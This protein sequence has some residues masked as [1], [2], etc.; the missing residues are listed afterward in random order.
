MKTACGKS[1]TK[2]VDAS[3]ITA[4]MAALA[5]VSSV[6]CK[7]LR[8][9]NKA[10]T[11]HPWCSKCCGLEFPCD[12]RAN[13]E[14]CKYMADQGTAWNSDSGGGWNDARAYGGGSWWPEEWWQSKVE[15]Q[16]KVGRQSAG[17][18][19]AS[20]SDSWWQSK[21]ETQSQR[22]G[23]RKNPSRTQSQGFDQEW[24]MV[25]THSTNSA[26]SSASSSKCPR[27]SEQPQAKWPRE[28][29]REEDVPTEIW[30]SVWEESG[31][32]EKSSTVPKWAASIHEGQA[33]PSAGP[34]NISG[35]GLFPQVHPDSRAAMSYPQCVKCCNK[36]AHGSCLV[37]C[38]MS[39][40]QPFVQ[41]NKELALYRGEKGIHAKLK[42][43]EMVNDPKGLELVCY[44][45]LTAKWRTD[46]KDWLGRDFPTNAPDDYYESETKNNAEQ[47]SH[48]PPIIVVKRIFAKLSKNST[49][50]PTETEIA[51]RVLT[52]ISKTVLEEVEQENPGMESNE[53]KRV[54][55][56]RMQEEWNKLTTRA[57]A[58]VSHA[59]DFHSNMTMGCWHVYTC[60]CRH[61]QPA[62][63]VVK[64]GCF[65]AIIGNNKWLFLCRSDNPVDYGTENGIADR[66]GSYYCPI[67]NEKFHM[68]EQW[69]Y[70][71]FIFSNM[72][73]EQSD[74]DPAR[75]KIMFAW[76]N[77]AD[78]EFPLW[79]QEQKIANK[80]KHARR[81]RVE[82]M[83]SVLKR[84]VLL[85][86][87]TNPANGE[88]IRDVSMN[89]IFLA[90]Q[91]LNDQAE[92][93]FL[94]HA[95]VSKFRSKIMPENERHGKRIFCGDSNMTVNTEGQAMAGIDLKTVFGDDCI[96][97][98]P[99]MTLTDW[100]LIIDYLLCFA[101][102][103]D[104]VNANDAEI[105]AKKQDRRDKNLKP[106]KTGINNNQRAIQYMAQRKEEIPDTLTKCMDVVN[107]MRST[108]ANMNI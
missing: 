96:D 43:D 68:A 48:D 17:N 89:E 54:H 91:K 76:T 44:K 72:T 75:D 59:S 41:M 35:P 46:G 3:N 39:N 100:E 85:K 24:N 64:R 83:I 49:H 38:T 4:A 50:V 56:L 53:F 66:Q 29:D 10:S 9:D 14:E 106:S 5:A 22:S 67:C 11:D 34:Y 55:L 77:S 97:T 26:S 12:K 30:D 65:T 101:D 105:E 15:W 74:F 69:P 40:M 37:R 42:N 86:Q 63:E 104:I 32:W 58:K 36:Y 13:H 94:K 78:N 23:W 102:L 92:K 82:L 108:F 71:G 28:E 98:I 6:I 88:I 1:T 51:H 93:T 7:T 84:C 73:S 81:E 107:K 70:R 103:E 21:V 27:L 90:V 25:D 31:W 18:D 19:K 8:C 2:K 47:K 20:S 61:K 57:Q 79:T 95:D 87:L 62:G 45:C 60:G 52:H 33:P 99:M 16:S 80:D